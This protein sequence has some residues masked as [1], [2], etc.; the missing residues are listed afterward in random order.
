[1]PTECDELLLNP[2]YSALARGGA[3]FST[4]IVQNDTGIVHRKITRY[5]YVG[6]YVIDFKE[7]SDEMRRGLR[8]FFILQWG[9]AY[10]FRF[11]PPDDHTLREELLTDGF[12]NPATITAGGDPLALHLIKTYARAAR[13]YQ[14]RIVKPA[15]DTVRLRIGDAFIEFETSQIGASGLPLYG[16]AIY[17]G[18]FNSGGVTLDYTT[19]DITFDAAARTQF[20]GLQAHVSCEFHI[21]AAFGTD[22]C[23]MAT[24]EVAISDWNGIEIN[25]VLPA[26]LGIL[27]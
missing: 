5:D 7:L 21:P 13:R 6:R 19:G 15:W 1:M 2:H 9:Q 8:E 20:N 25:E 27:I 11:L 4:N 17:G 16:Q 24:D 22:W 3:E 18:S 23:D 26:E 12:Y 14:R 10:A